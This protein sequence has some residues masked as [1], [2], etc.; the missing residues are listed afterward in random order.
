MCRVKVIDA[1]DVS[2]QFD[3][4]KGRVGSYE[5][6]HRVELS[7][8]LEATLTSFTA[9]RCLF[10]I[11]KFVMCLEHSCVETGCFRLFSFLSID[12]GSCCHSIGYGRCGRVRKKII[13]VT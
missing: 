13:E 7:V 12:M 4:P 1:T 11:P 9:T 3:F 8:A 6:Y 5:A 10:F 2:H